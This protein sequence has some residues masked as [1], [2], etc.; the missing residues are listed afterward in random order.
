ML[1][2]ILGHVEMAMNKTDAGHPLCSDLE[3]IRRAAERSSELTKQLLA[4]ARKQTISPKTLN[5]NETVERMLSM[6]HRLIG[7]NIYLEWLPDPNLW[8]ISIDP[9]QMDQILANLCVNA[10][11]AITGVGKVTIET[12]SH[13]LDEVYCAAHKDFVPGQYVSL[14]VSDD[15]LRYGQRNPVTSF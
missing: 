4:F 14:T 5:L 8:N 2:V 13:T 9:S 6:L 15:V 7:E 3:A 11:D 12:G 10:S 1:G